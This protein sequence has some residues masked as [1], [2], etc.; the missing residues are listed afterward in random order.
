MVRARTPPSS[1]N[2]EHR[3]QRRGTGRARI[4]DVAKLAGVAPITVSRVLNAPESVAAETL[5]RVPMHE[6]LRGTEST[7]KSLLDSCRTAQDLID[8]IKG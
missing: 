8:K 3:R 6:P 7:T 2:A 5:Q 1:S 4:T